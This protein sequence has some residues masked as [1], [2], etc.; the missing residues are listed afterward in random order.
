MTMEVFE[1]AKALQGDI[2]ITKN[3]IA[4]IGVLLE[5]CRKQE[6]SFALRDTAD[7]TSPVIHLSKEE[8]LPFFEKALEEYKRGVDR[9]EK[10]FEEL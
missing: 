6:R 5:V 9:L 3:Q 1:K 10:E 8:A 4:K 2:S 7:I